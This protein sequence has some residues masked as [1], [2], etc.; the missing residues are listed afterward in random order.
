MSEFNLGQNISLNAGRSEGNPT[1]KP[2]IQDPKTSTPEIKK[3]EMQQL[4]AEAASLLTPKADD[5]LKKLIYMVGVKDT[6]IFHELL[7]TPGG[8]E[9][10]NP[11]KKKEEDIPSITSNDKR[12]D[13]SSWEEYKKQTFQDLSDLLVEAWKYQ[14]SINEYGK[15]PDN[16]DNYLPLFYF[17]RI[18]GQIN[19]IIEKYSDPNSKQYGGY[20]DTPLTRPEWMSFNINNLSNAMGETEP[21]R[22]LTPFIA[23][24]PRWQFLAE[25]N[26]ESKTTLIKNLK[27]ML[28][29]LNDEFNRLANTDPQKGKTITE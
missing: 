28:S 23:G 9:L 15:I 19:F 1:E 21:A 22:V 24:E 26:E 17:Q 4:Y 25:D 14:Q 13:P 29:E 10:Y 8:N 20:S 18:V 6:L 3:T 12:I 5:I 16:P 2:V 11:N 7:R 27:N